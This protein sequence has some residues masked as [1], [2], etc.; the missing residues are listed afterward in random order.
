MDKSE[1]QPITNPFD[2]WLEENFSF[3][4]KTFGRVKL[5]EEHEKWKSTQIDYQNCLDNETVFDKFLK[6]ILENPSV[7]LNDGPPPKKFIPEHIYKQVYEY[8]KMYWNYDKYDKEHKYSWDCVQLVLPDKEKKKYEDEYMKLLKAANVDNLTKDQIIDLRQEESQVLEKNFRETRV[9]LKILK[10]SK[11]ELEKKLQKLQEK[12]EE[13]KRDLEAKR[14][15]IATLQS[16][17]AAELFQLFS[18][19]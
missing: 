11:T 2:A 9:A 10:K 7:L 4:F 14:K 16:G 17:S 19:A 3:V 8:A 12:H 13:A 6:R 15:E 18:A 5:N 1:S